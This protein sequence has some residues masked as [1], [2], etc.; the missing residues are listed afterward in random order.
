MVISIIITSKGSSNIP[1]GFI[2]PTTFGLG[3]VGAF[4]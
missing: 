4:T 2:N 1:Y 3:W